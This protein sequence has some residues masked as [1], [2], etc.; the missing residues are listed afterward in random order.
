MLSFDFKNSGVKANQMS[1]AAKRLSHRIAELKK[2]AVSGKLDLPEG[3][4]NLAGDTAGIKAVK[5]M[6]ARKISKKLGAV[7]VIGIGGSSLGA[8]AVAS[9]IGSARPLIFFDNIDPDSVAEKINILKRIYADGK[10]ALVV[11]VSKS[12]TT[13]ETSANFEAVL[14]WLKRNDN[15]WRERIV[16]VTDSG[17]PLHKKC[18]R[19]KFDVLSSPSHISGRFSFLSPVGL[20]P[21][22]AAGMDIGAFT[23][24]AAAMGNICL[25]ESISVN[26]ALRGA[27]TLWSSCRS[28]KNIC[29][30]FVFADKLEKLAVFVRNLAA[31]SL[32]KGGSGF[33]SMVSV[34]STDL[35]SMGQLYFGG[36]K[37]KFTVF[38]DSGPVAN[39]VSGVDLGRA[40]KAIELAVKKSYGRSRL[41]YYSVD[42]GRVT[43][44]SVGEL[45]AMKMFETVYLGYLMGVNVFDQPAVEFYKKVARRMLGK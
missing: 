19:E 44:R 31:E 37:D 11:P 24:G 33:T 41:P 21:L 28:G 16:A 27:I 42:L 3:F 1:V 10:H 17:S 15:K 38:L 2:A 22:G 34:G 35:H 7:A 20:F 12:G 43:P 9:A 6:A 32:S 36:P 23:G 14:N 8:E 5:K 13:I 18:L 40:I 4:V 39:V 29:N 25:S 30:N 45:M 26:P